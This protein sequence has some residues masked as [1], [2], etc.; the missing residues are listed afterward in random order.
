MHLRASIIR[1][2]K[3]GPST[4][5]PLAKRLTDHSREVIE[6][7]LADLE[8]DGIVEKLTALETIHIYRLTEKGFQI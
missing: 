6:L 5:R 2:L 8:Q 1:D 4:I 3:T 7:E